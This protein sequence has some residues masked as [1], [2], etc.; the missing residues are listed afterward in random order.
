MEYDTLP[1]E[2]SNDESCYSRATMPDRYETVKEQVTVRDAY[3]ETIDIPPVYETIEEVVLVKEQS[4][5][6]IVVPAVYRTVYERVLVKEATPIINEEYETVTEQV[7]VQPEQ[8]E[9]VR[10]KTENCFS[11]NPD[12]CY[13]M[14]WVVTPAQYE[15]QSRRILTGIGGQNGGELPARYEALPRQ[16]LVQAETVREVIVP[17]VYETITKQVVVQPARNEQIQMPAEYA[18]VEIRQLVEAGGKTKWTAIP[19]PEQTSP[20]LIKQ[21]QIALQSKGYYVNGFVDGVVGPLTKEALK[22]YQRRTGLPIGNLNRETLI[23]LGL[24]Y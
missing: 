22:N 1:P 2:A 7:L 24:T 17:A 10:L 6:L 16:V 12:D 11:D 13:Y 4:V 18:T 15:T 14:R 21:M 20:I 8:K 3:I 23:S 19:C 5:E 9:W